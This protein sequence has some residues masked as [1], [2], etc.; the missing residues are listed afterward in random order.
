MAVSCYYAFKQI[1]VHVNKPEGDA[2]L[3]EELN[4]FFARFEVDPPK[5]TTPYPMVRNSFTLAEQE[6]RRTVRAADLRNGFG[7][8]GAPGGVL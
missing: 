8:D 7:P 1:A 2:S 6:V 4:I 5:A 3:T